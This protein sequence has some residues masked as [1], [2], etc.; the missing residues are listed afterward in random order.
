MKYIILE[1]DGKDTGLIHALRH[2]Y[3]KLCE[4]HLTYE[5]NVEKAE[6]AGDSNMAA[7]WQWYADREWGKCEA[8]RQVIQ[9]LK[10]EME[11]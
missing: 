5:K 10:E 11:S 3:T 1:N 2:R 4:S 6:F 7:Y 9:D 8:V